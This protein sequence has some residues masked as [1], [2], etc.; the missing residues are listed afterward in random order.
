M[1]K[2]VELNKPNMM[3]MPIGSESRCLAPQ[4]DC[5]CELPPKALRASRSHD[6]QSE[7]WKKTEGF[8]REFNAVREADFRFSKRSPRLSGSPRSCASSSSVGSIWDKSGPPTFAHAC[9]ECVSYGWQATRRL[10]TVAAEPRRR[11]SR[12]PNELRLASHLQVV[13]SKRLKLPTHSG[14][15]TGCSLRVQERRFTHTLAH[16]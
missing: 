16:L 1:F 3:T 6:A 7:N 10:S 15:R 11:T 4:E 5:P 12:S 9:Q 14:D 2:A 8:T 13:D